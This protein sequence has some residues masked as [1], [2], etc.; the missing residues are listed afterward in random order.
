MLKRNIQKVKRLFPGKKFYILLLNILGLFIISIFDLLGVAAVLPIIQLA[1]GADYSSGYLALLNSLLGGTDRTGMIFYTSIL[2]VVCFLVKGILSLWI[3]WISTGFIAHQQVA[4]SVTVLSGYAHESYLK[5]RQRTA[6]QIMRA[7]SDAVVS[8]YGSYIGG[9]ISVAGELGTILLLSTMLIVLM[10]QQAIIAFI[11]FGLSAY[12]L[13]KFLKKKN[14]ELGLISIN[15]A[16]GSTAAILESINGFRENKIHGTADRSLYRYQDKQLE[17]AEAGRRKNFYFEF[18]KYTLEIVFILGIA[19]I[20]GLMVATEG[21][22]SA[23]Y[24]LVFATACVRILPSFTRLV[25]SLGSIRAGGA[26]SQLLDREIRKLSD[27]EKLTMLKQEPDI[28]AFARVN[29]ELMPLAVDIVDLSFRYPDGENKVLDGINFKVPAGS[30]TAFV[31]GS[32]SGKT[33]LV[34]IILG[35]IEPTQGSVLSKGQPISRDLAAWFQRIGY[36]PQDVFLGDSTLREAVAFGLKDQEIDDKRV[37]E[38]L[39][40]A[41]MVDVVDSLEKGIHTKIGERGTRLSGGQ[42]QRVG[43]ARALYRNPSIL[44]LDEATSA[45]DN[46]TESKIAAS[47]NK[48]AGKVTVIIVAHRLSTIREVDQLLFL[49]QG[50]IAAQGSFTEVQEQNLEFARLVKLGQLPE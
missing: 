50:K 29:R 13:Q 19:L 36:V 23:P 37:L 14:A 41:E 25:A 47:I 26:P 7:A 8:T 40:A 28:G 27:P 44:I 4:T 46:E 22:D 12:L 49:S 43:I 2:L 31:G 18:P 35:L 32:G 21:I 5:H 42:R 6:A 17:A 16:M 9:I 48:L 34:D 33:T 30:S 24:L 38:V 39:A 15:A 1:M 45:L 11:Y 3:K 10:P 20:L